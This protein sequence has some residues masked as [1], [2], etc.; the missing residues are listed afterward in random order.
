MATTAQ[1]IVNRA[2]ARNVANRLTSLTSDTSEMLHR[3][4]A[5]AIELR[6][7]LLEGNR[8]FFQERE[9]KASS[10]AASSRVLDLSA[11]ATPCFRL[12]K[13]ELP[14]GTE[15]SVVDL[16]D[17]DAELAPRGYP[18]G[19]TIVEVGSE[20]GS[21][22]AV[23]ITVFYVKGVASLTLTGALSQTV[24]IDDEYASL[25]DNRLAKYLAQ[26]DTGRD[27]QEV[28]DLDAE[29]QTGLVSY[30]DFLNGVGGTQAL[31]HVLPGA[32]DKP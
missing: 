7:Q 5:D 8:T 21:S 23:N 6:Q 32:N 20:W 11:L 13:L 15:I 27:P 9:V 28:T 31:R 25:L 29:Y 14:S 30:L 10:N 26:K 4:N 3:I 12:L 18:K 22:G 19:K 16:R 1:Q 2:I 24:T 17:Q